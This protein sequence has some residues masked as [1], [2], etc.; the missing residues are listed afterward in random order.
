MPKAKYSDE[1]GDKWWVM[2][3]VGIGTFMGTLSSSIVNISLPT[4]SDYFQAKLSLVAWVM[5]AYL[6]TT[7]SLLI[8]FG[9]L[10]DITGRK[11]IYTS[12]FLI[13]TCGTLLCSISGGIYQLIFF[14]VIQATGGAMMVSNSAA[15]I[16]E[17]FPD[18]E[19]GKALG[20]IGSIVALGLTCGPPV[21]GF[22]LEKLGWRW[23][24]YVN[25]PVGVIGFGLAV[26]ILKKRPILLLGQRFDVK[27]A[28]FLACSLILLLLGLNHWQHTGWKSPFIHW[29]FA[30]FLFFGTLFLVTETKSENPIIQLSFF[31]HRI[32]GFGNLNVLLV[33]LSHLS[34]IFLMPFYLTQVLGLSP[35]QMG[36]ILI[37]IPLC[38]SVVAPFSGWLSDKIGTRFLTTFGLL[39]AGLSILSIVQLDL[40]SNYQDVVLRLIVLGVGVGMFSSPNNSSI[41]GSVSKE[42]YGRAAG[43]LATMRNLGMV[44]GVSIASMIFTSSE[45]HYL[46]QLRSQILENSLMSKMAFTR[47]FHNVYMVTGIVCL[48]AAFFSYLRGESKAKYNGICRIK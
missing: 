24:F 18:Q 44:M 27:G 42:N 22:I 20:I 10:A 28:L 35:L 2:L 38:L 33:Y 31:R 1:Y 13:F 34:V 23:I 6:L 45:N 37:T 17:T 9:R 8:T 16:T 29:L 4:I 47:A 21:G 15:L 40:N 7:S 30:G 25:I 3:V 14:R 5:M 32:F 48:I 41:M 19:R 12:G 39:L 11:L 46:L 43:I 36:W 26:L